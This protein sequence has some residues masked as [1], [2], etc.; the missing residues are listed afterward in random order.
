MAPMADA[1]VRL[2][3][4]VLWEDHARHIGGGEFGA[5]LPWGDG[6]DGL[7]PGASRVYFAWRNM[8]RGWMA[9][10]RIE[11]KPAFQDRTK[12]FKRIVA[13]G[14]F[15]IVHPWMP[16]AGGDT[17]T[18]T[19]DR[20]PAAIPPVLET[21]GVRVWPVYAAGLAADAAPLAWWF[22]TEPE[23]VWA[24]SPFATPAV[25]RMKFDLRS[26]PEEAWGAADRN[27]KAL[28]WP[29]AAAILTEAIRLDHLWSSD[30]FVDMSAPFGA[31]HGGAS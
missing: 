26:L 12:I 14:P 8:I 7:A 1:I 16:R 27:A 22:A 5:V 6:G 29:I 10:A 25:Q 18:M 21:N 4:A 28:D 11:D 24:D 13:E 2:N 30:Y 9:L 19:G 23:G 3:G 15:A 17:G 20:P 31:A